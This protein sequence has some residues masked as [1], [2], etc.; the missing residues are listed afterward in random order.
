MSRSLPQI[1]SLN[2]G[3]NAPQNPED[4]SSLLGD[5]S[6]PARVR[7]CVTC[8]ARKVKCDKGSPCSNCKRYG[9]AC[10]LAP[11][12]PPRWV[13]RVAPSASSHTTSPPSTA[14]PQTPVM[15]SPPN[16]S[17]Q[18]SEA[19]HVME[20]LEK[21]EQLVK[22]LGGEA[23]IRNNMSKSPV[24]MTEQLS[25]DDTS[26]QDHVRSGIFSRIHDEVRLRDWLLETRELIAT[27]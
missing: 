15:S 8:R 11:Y 25:L 3:F 26:Q 20:R 14:P 10:V 1:P 17:T 13:R 21:L 7:S 27:A 22:D 23:A 6:Q 19:T 18:K 24:Q 5:L 9:I 12:R 2:T 16:P 4:L